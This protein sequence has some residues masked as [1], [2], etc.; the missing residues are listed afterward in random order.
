M[1]KKTK[2]TIKLNLVTEITWHPPETDGSKTVQEY[3]TEVINLHEKN[4]HAI[5]VAAQWHFLGYCDVSHRAFYA[6]LNKINAIE[7]FTQI[8]AFTLEVWW[9]LIR[10][11]HHNPKLEKLLDNP[12]WWKRFQ[13]ARIFEKHQKTSNHIFIPMED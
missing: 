2:P 8:N 13:S 4:R 7:T 5:L 11:N 12:Q 10:S 1:K 6:N 9:Q 3:V